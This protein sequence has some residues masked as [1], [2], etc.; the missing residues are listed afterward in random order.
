MELRGTTW[1]ML[2]LQLGM[3]PVDHSEIG[4]PSCDWFFGIKKCH[5]NGYNG[6][7]KEQL[8]EGI[9]HSHP[10][11]NSDAVLVVDVT[12][13]A[14]ELDQTYPNLGWEYAVQFFIR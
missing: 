13:R 2:A 9:M 4:E 7:N 10:A 11:A 3:L 14:I 8:N 6:S 5:H 1:L 12:P